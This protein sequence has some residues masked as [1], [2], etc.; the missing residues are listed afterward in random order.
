[1][2]LI[3]KIRGDKISQPLPRSSV[4]D[5]SMITRRISL[6]SRAWGETDNANFYR[7]G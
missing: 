2:N 1:M 3:A 6:S 7:E 4:I 5:S